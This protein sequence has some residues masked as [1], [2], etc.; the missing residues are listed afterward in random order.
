MPSPEVALEGEA[1]VLQQLERAVDR[2]VPHTLI[3]GAHLLEHVLDAEVAN[4]LEED[5]RDEAP[6]SRAAQ[7]LAVHVLDQAILQLLRCCGSAR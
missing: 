7:A 6:L 3:D 2:G 5:V 1:A 4:A